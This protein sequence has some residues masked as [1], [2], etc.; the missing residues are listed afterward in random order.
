MNKFQ[1][2][3]WHLIFCLISISSFST[4]SNAKSVHLLVV[5]SYSKPL[6]KALVKIDQLKLSKTSDQFGIVKFDLDC[7]QYLLDIEAGKYEHF[8]HYIDIDDGS[9]YPRNSPLLISKIEEPDHKIII[10]ANPLEHTSLDMATPIAII[11]GE[12]LISK[13][14]STL[15]EILQLEPGLSFSS[16]GPAVARPVIRGLSAGRVM[17][18]NNQMR[19][20][21]AS[22]TSSDHDVGIEPL[23]L[24]QIEV[25]KGP[26]SLLYG[27]GAIGGVI[28][29]VDNKIQTSPVDELTGGIEVRLGDSATQEKAS[30]FTLNNGVNDWTWH[31]DGFRNETGNIKIPVSA[32]SF[33]QLSLE[34]EDTS[35]FHQESILSNSYSNTM[36]GSLGSSFIFDDGYAGLSV[37]FIEKQY[38]LPGH[39]EHGGD[40]VDGEEDVYIDMEQS[41]VH[42]QSQFDLS[43]GALDSLFVG[44]ANT[45]YQHIE[46]EGEA[47]GTRFENQANELKSY[48]KHKP[49]LDW[50]GV[51]GIQMTSRD[52]SAIGEEAFIPKSTTNS[53]ALFWLE[54]KHFDSIK[55]ELGLRFEQQDITL[56]SGVKRSENG[57]N[58][59][60]GSVYTIKKHNKLA[61][62]FSHNVRF[63]SVEEYFSFGPHLASGTFEIGNPNLT[64]EY[65]N[66]LDFS[67]RF[68]EAFGKDKS[69]SGEINLFYNQFTDY[70][71]AQSVVIDDECVLSTE[72]SNGL[73]IEQAVEDELSLICYKQKD[74]NYYGAEFK[75]TSSLAKFNKH[76]IDI[77]VF[78]D[79]L[80]AKLNSDENLPRIP[81]NKIGFNL[82]YNYEDFTTDLVW[83]KNEAQND[84]GENELATPAFDL[85]N[86]EFAYRISNR[87]SDWY[88]FLKGKNL[89]NEEIRDH[90][91]FI[92]DLAP[93]T[94]RNWALGFRY[95]F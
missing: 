54:E 27:S 63:P 91:S 21:D 19:V 16:F 40:V 9:D 66:N 41:T 95:N 73:A 33:A 43:I 92:K 2:K 39:S 47:I 84:V 70:I 69:F 52:F 77:E 46:F 88:L 22:T 35:E 71:F 64:K 8:H 86:L 30:V 79:Y 61:L 62:N 14:A 29:T 36:G 6:I 13:R 12:E 4:Y 60:V 67:Y 32:E 76:Q 93:R 44:Y 49:Y 31:I 59:S 15:G 28:N 1:F 50:S 89:L 23:L 45:D 72:N 5:D 65:S 87:S 55:W 24:Q 78:A 85:V 51:A 80:V 17:V 68:E 57:V 11:S 81:A 26:A 56:D 18:T 94:K 74:A 53:K 7:G 83:S 20:Q 48:I 38:G 82:V 10:H 58:Y 3:N 34:D 42:F 37:S 90:G 25:V 75:L